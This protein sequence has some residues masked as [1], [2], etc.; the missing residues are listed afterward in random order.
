MLQDFLS[1]CANASSS[2]PVTKAQPGAATGFKSLFASGVLTQKR[3]NQPAAIG[4]A[5][6]ANAAAESNED[7]DAPVIELIQEAGKVSK[8]VV[9]CTCCRRIELECEY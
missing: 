6:D 7:L 4:G 5:N 3:L 1:S 9:T 2:S 8:I